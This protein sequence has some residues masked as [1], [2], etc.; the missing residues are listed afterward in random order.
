MLLLGDGEVR[1]EEVRH[2]IMLP[3]W[4]WYTVLH[5]IMQVSS[6]ECPTDLPYHRGMSYRLA[7][8]QRIFLN[9]RDTYPT[10]AKILFFMLRLNGWRYE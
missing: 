6:E 9:E 8:I 4:S 1:N 10:L 2:T 5:V 7:L 3:L